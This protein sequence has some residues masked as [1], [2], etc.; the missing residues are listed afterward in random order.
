[1]NGRQGLLRRGSGGYTFIEVLIALVILALAL[2]AIVGAFAYASNLSE[3]SRRLTIASQTA[4]AKIGELRALGYTNLPVG[5]YD[6]AGELPEQLNRGT[7][8]IVI[9]QWAADVKKIEV[10]VV[11]RPGTITGGRVV[12]TTLVSRTE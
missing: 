11:W 12:L 3:Y 1:M 2:T 5:T 10:T 6:F 9:S 8:T 7:A 4:E